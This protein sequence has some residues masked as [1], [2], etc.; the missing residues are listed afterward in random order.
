[1]MKTQFFL[2]SFL[3]LVQSFTVDAQAGNHTDPI[4]DPSLW[5]RILKKYVRE[6]KLNGINLNVVNYAEIARDPGLINIAHYG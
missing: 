5:D 1:M 4:R 3:L 2:L 6:G